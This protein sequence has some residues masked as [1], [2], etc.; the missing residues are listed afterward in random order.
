MNTSMGE[1]DICADESPV[2]A[3]DCGYQT[4]GGL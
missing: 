4:V 1:I 2:E 3:I